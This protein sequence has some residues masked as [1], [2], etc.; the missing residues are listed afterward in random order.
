MRPGGILTGMAPGS[1][2]T[3]PPPKLLALA[4]WA[5]G[6]SACSHY[7][8]PGAFQE[9][10]EVA[11]PG[12]TG[13]IEVGAAG[14]FN[15]Q[16]DPIEGRPDAETG[17]V[18]PDR[19]AASP[20]LPWLSYGVA[21]GERLELRLRVPAGAPLTLRLQRQLSG[22]PERDEARGFAASVAGG[23]GL[24][25][26]RSGGSTVTYFA[27]DAGLPAGWRWNITHL[28]TLTPWLRWSSFTG[29]ALAIAPNGSLSALQWGLGLGHRLHWDDFY[30]Q[31]ELGRLGGSAGEYSLSGFSGGL[32]A[33]LRL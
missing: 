10:P 25:L 19:A 22:A 11:G 18:P 6:A 20:P 23:G 9:S 2:P 1:R 24:L 16:G 32:S 4:A 33:G 21:L 8:L 13:R 31:L 15:L 17:E 28:T 30:V 26:G 29:P 7:R 12:R 5:L 27:L 3:L 14:G